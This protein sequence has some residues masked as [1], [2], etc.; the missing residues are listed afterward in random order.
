MQPIPVKLILKKYREEQPKDC[1]KFG[2]RKETANSEMRDKYFKINTTMPEHKKKVV[3]SNFEIAHNL[4][5]NNFRERA[6][7]R[8]DYIPDAKGLAQLREKLKK[9]SLSLLKGEYGENLCSYN[10]MDY[11]FKVA[12]N[13]KTSKEAMQELHGVHFDF[14]HSKNDWVSQ[15]RHDYKQS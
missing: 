8:S 11:G 3:E 4:G 6:W 15:Y 1:V 7:E 13:N 9:S 2:F 5:A 14:G 12:K 10:K